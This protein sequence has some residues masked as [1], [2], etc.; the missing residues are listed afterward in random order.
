M[1]VAH[2]QKPLPISH[3]SQGFLWKRRREAGTLAQLS[4]AWRTKRA[5]S[6]GALLNL[7]MANAFGSTSWETLALQTPKLFIAEDEHF[8]HQRYSWSSVELPGAEG[9]FLIRNGTGALM[10]D[11]YAVRSFLA[12]YDDPTNQWNASRFTL[13]G[14]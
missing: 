2:E 3:S 5:S 12:A 13:H 8:V 4:A 7:D 9:S 14:H 1:R 11:Q 10:G 6:C